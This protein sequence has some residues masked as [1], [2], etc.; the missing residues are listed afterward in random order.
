MLAWAGWHS[1][2]KLPPPPAA[3]PGTGDL[4][5]AAQNFAINSAAVAVCGYLLYR[6]YSQQQKDQQQIA[7]E[8]TLG[9]LQVRFSRAA[10]VAGSGS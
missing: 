9:R 10:V 1:Q 4:T 7:R 6:D 2:N 8:E 5:Q 3:T